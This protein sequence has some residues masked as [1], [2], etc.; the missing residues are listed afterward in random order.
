MNKSLKEYFIESCKKLSFTIVSIDENSFKLTIPSKYQSLFPKETFDISFEENK[1]PEI[2]V[3]SDD[4]FLFKK[5]SNLIIEQTKGYTAARINFKSSNLFAACGE[6][7]LV[8]YKFSIYGH[9]F[10]QFV[11]GFIYDFSK[12]EIRAFKDM[13]FENEV[14]HLKDARLA[15]PEESVLNEI[16]NAFEQYTSSYMNRFSKM[17]QFEYNRLI[18]QE[19][20][21]IEDYYDLID[22]EN[23]T[24]ETYNENEEMT[25]AEHTRLLQTEKEHL[26]SQQRIKYTLN[27]DK[28]SIEPISILFVKS[29]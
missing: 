7:L 19:I 17:K 27:S 18:D 20:E 26:I 16:K 23:A 25:N 4:S 11:K 28:I 9:A 8:W 29:E 12:S 2:E 1:N 5:I 21:R 6:Y 3:I 10:E 13:E 22:Q 14:K 15:L 24:A